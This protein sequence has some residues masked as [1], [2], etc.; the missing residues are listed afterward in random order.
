MR[1]QGLRTAIAGITLPNPASVGLHEALGFE[2]VGLLGEIGWK[3]DQWLDVGWWQLQLLPAADGPPP[4]P[5][6]PS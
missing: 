5:G 4:E 3:E 2:R 6:A 1:A